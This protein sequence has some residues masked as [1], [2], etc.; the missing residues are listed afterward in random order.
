MIIYTAFEAYKDIY[1]C[2]Y[3]ILK[4]FELSKIDEKM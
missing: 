2:A 1:L 3:F 4:T